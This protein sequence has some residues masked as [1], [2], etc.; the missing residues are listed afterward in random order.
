METFLSLRHIN[1][2]FHA[3]RA[4]RD[5]SLDFM[6]GE[7]HCLAGQ[8]GCG[9]STLIKIMSGV[10]RPDEGAEITLGGKNWS[11]LTPAASVAQGIQVIYQDLSLFP[12]LS[13]WENIAVNH[14]HH[15]LFV[16]RRRLREV[17]QAAMISINVTLP[18][19]TLVSELSIARCQLVAICRALAQ[20]ARLIV[21]DEPT[22]SLTHQEVQGLLQVVH[23]LRERGICV[24][25]VSHRLEEV[26]EVSDRISVL[27]DG[28]LVGTFPAAEMTTKQLG[29][30]MTGQEF[31]YQVR[32]LWQGKSSTP[33][34]EVRNSNQDAIRHG[35]GY[36]SEDRMSRG[37]VM[38]QSIE[39]NII[40]T[41]FHKVKDRFG[42]LSEAKVRDLVDRLIKALT[43]KVSDPHLPVNTLSGGNAQRVSIAKWLAIGP[44]LLILDSPTVGVDIANKAGIYGIISDL[45]AHGIA[46]LMICDEIEEAWYQ[47][48]RILVMQKGQIT[49]SFLPDSSSQ[50]RIA[51]VVN[52]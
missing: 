3:T 41:V 16:N 40:S 43:I 33:V 12:N 4:L 42:F 37:L 48:H 6:S 44:R 38:A 24:V 15:G 51:E 9:K 39:D 2:T 11:K 20:D 32:E 27:K 36:V 10:Y 1:K 47:S 50:A 25:F 31:E 45:A 23:Q 29:F 5:V 46:V 14:Y 35:I 18:L 26:M 34:L 30:L 22:A 21:M 19:D 52:G 13:V 49:H 28:E 8:N 7:V 17:A